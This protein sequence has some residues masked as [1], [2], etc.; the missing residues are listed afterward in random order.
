[1][2]DPA[3][4]PYLRWA[5]L[6][7]D[8][9]FNLAGS[10]LSNFPLQEL[11][12][13]MEDLEI[14][15]PGLYGYGA[16]RERLARKTGVPDDCLVFS[17]GAS[18]ANFI[19]LAAIIQ[20]GDDVLIEQ[21]TY[22]PILRIAEWLGARIHRFPRHFE[23]DW[24]VDLDQLRGLIG[25]ATRVLIL[26]NLHNPS[27]ALLD[28]Q[29]LAQIGRMAGAVGAVVLVD[30][31]YLECLFQAKPPSAFF[32]GHNFVVTSSLTKAYGLSGLRCGW[33][34]APPNLVRRM[35]DMID[36]TYGVPA[37]SAERLSVIALDHLCQIAQRA[38]DLLDRNRALLN[39]FLQSHQNQLQCKNSEFGTTVAPRLRVGDVDRLCHVLRDQFETS[40]VP[41]RFFEAPQHFRVGMGGP[42]DILQAGLDRTSTA[43]TK[44]T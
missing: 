20:T 14:T 11:P 32:L 35:H 3:D 43:L 22:Q 39:S 16:L 21:P 7:S 36:L 5:K 38:R 8:A 31:V 41:G 4:L 25:P 27:S 26:S 10:G 1:M 12:V 19:A 28:N 18:M 2:S 40:V 24:N 13:R 17:L 15:G 9:R 42:T 37:H 33:V 44:L 34:L 30:E 29:T 6:R 23:T